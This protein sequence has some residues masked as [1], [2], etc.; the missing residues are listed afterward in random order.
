[1]QCI[2]GDGEDGSKGKLP[3][4]SLFCSHLK[5]GSTRILTVGSLSWSETCALV[6]LQKK[7]LDVEQS[8]WNHL[9]EVTGMLP[10]P[11]L[12]LPEP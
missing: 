3:E 9:L 12:R 4:H 7:V 10:R 2:C 1:M 6:P 5:E 8:D 11:Q